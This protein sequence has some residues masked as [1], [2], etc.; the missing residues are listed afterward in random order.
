MEENMKVSMKT[1]FWILF[2]LLSVALTSSAQVTTATFY[3]VVGDTSQAVLPGATVTMTH[4]GTG[5][6]NSKVTDEK[7]EFAFTFLPAGNYTLKIELP[8][9]KTLLSSD[10]E[11]G[12]AQNVR[13]I[14]NLE[15]G[16]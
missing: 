2:L 3:G 6:A 10:F 9:F 7:G 16:G 4:L 1:T 15:V 5:A 14:F 12:A 13:R 8:G 11:L